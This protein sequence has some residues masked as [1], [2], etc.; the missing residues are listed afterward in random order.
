MKQ[1]YN[2]EQL[3][4]DIICLCLS[5]GTKVQGEI[6][7]CK[8]GLVTISYDQLRKMI[9]LRVGVKNV[10]LTCIDTNALPGSIILQSIVDLE[11]SNMNGVIR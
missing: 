5:R 6:Y 8:I 10:P 9:S 3:M 1:I 2:K 4:R 11:D 7:V